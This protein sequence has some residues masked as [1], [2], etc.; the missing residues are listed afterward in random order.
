D[1]D[2]KTTS[3]TADSPTDIDGNNAL[4][5]MADSKLSEQ[6]PDGLQPDNSGQ[7]TDKENTLIEEQQ[8]T[9]NWL[10]QIPDEP[11]LFLK[12]KFKYQ[13]QQRSAQPI[14][15]SSNKQW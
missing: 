10:K 2:S 11:G 13:Y 7:L 9:R 12:R 6:K 3:G 4:P 5:G 15:D 1:K 14:L 8:A